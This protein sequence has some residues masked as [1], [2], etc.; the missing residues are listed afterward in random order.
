MD[1]MNSPGKLFLFALAACLGGAVVQAQADEGPSR[2]DP[3]LELQARHELLAG[4]LAHNAFGRPLAL[5]SSEQPR[6]VSGDVYAVLDYPFT[7][8]SRAFSSPHTWC[9]VLILH[10]NTKYCRAGAGNTLSVRMG[11]KNARDLDDSFALKFAFRADVPRPGYAAARATSASGPLGSRD[12]RIAMEAM[13]LPDGRS[14]MRLHYSYGF[15]GVAK[16]ATQ[17]YLATAGSGKVGFTRERNRYVRGMRGAVERNAMRYYLAVESYLSSLAQAPG[18]QFASRIERWFDATE[19]YRPQLHEIERA[20]YLAMKQ[21][22]Y[23]R[24]Q[25]FAAK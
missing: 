4:A 1:A 16:L 6:Q 24:Q 17:G 10:M 3:A 13:P 11:R 14:F 20:D 22:E 2:A 15:G 5:E 12:Y 23:A 21:R 18:R 8:V 19:Q 9:E 7:T 25:A